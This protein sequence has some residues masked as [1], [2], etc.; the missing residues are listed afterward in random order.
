MTIYWSMNLNYF[1]RQTSSSIQS[2]D[3][4]SSN[5]RSAFLG[6]SLDD[7]SKDRIFEHNSRLEN[8]RLTAEF[9]QKLSILSLNPA[10]PQVQIICPKSEVEQKDYQVWTVSIDQAFYKY[11]MSGYGHLFFGLSE[12][13]ILQHSKCNSYFISCIARQPQFDKS[14][15]WSRSLVYG[16]ASLEISNSAR[17]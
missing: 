16:F 4:T 7:C 11:I 10:A 9:M 2:Q 14:F 17:F 1:F 12:Y 5:A 3:S 15:V 8:V 13:A 6:T